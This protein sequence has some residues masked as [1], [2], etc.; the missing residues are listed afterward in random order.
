MPATPVLRAHVGLDLKTAPAA[1]NKVATLTHETVE[2]EFEL[3]ITPDGENSR[4]HQ[5]MKQAK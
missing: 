4:R 1:L 5:L 3:S 2:R